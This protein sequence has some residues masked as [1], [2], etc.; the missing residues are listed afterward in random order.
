M[1]FLAGVY[2]EII[3]SNFTSNSAVE[4]GNALFLVGDAMQAPGDVWSSP[5]LSPSLSPPAPSSRDSKRR[6]RLNRHAFAPY[7]YQLP[8]MEGSMEGS[9]HMRSSRV[10]K[11]DA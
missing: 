1:A 4:R 7:T 6:A 2:L 3:E 10:R 5:S 8:W 9:Q 11:C